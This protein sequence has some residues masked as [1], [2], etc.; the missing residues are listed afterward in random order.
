MKKFFLLL[1]LGFISY[2]ADAQWTASYH[3][4]TLPFIG[5]NKQ[6]GNKW[7]P[8]M[9]IGTNI[10][11]EY[12][13]LEFV[14]NRILFH[15]DRVDFYGGLGARVNNFTGL[16]IPFGLNIYPFEKKD[17]GFH[18]E[19]APIIGEYTVLRGSFGLRY[20]FLKN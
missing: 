5:I 13:P 19:A 15:N 14:F 9:R 8:E 4:S 6:I 10:Q 2:R 7:I 20:R 1:F 16:V 3:Q 12:L 17:F 11:L 18:I